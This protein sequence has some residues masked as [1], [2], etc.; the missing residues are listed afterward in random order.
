[1]TQ[2]RR[3]WA[4]LLLVAIVLGLLGGVA[5]ALVAGARRSSS[6]VDRY[7]EH[8]N[9][10]AVQMYSPGITQEQASALPGVVRADGFSY[11]PFVAQPAGTIRGGPVTANAAP[12]AMLDGT[13]KLLAGR[14]PRPGEADAAIVN[15]P[16]VKAFGV[17]V[18]D[19]VRLRAFADDDATGGNS[20]S[21]T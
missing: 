7:F 2:L 1:R 4:T 8:A 15:E 3:R 10:Y 5:T 16:Y 14:Y 20:T 13:Y 18:G 19:T 17:E 9:P 11:I 21:G 6:V 12:A